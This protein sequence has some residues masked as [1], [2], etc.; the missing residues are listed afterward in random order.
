MQ[1]G[2]LPF[3]AATLE[4]EGFAHEFRV[5]L[6]MFGSGPD[7]FDRC[8]DLMHDARERNRQNPDRPLAVVDDRRNGASPRVSVIVSLYDA[9]TKLRTLLTGT[10]PAE[11][12]TA[13]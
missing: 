12:G 9:A 1:Y 6:A 7:A 3:V 13:R 8:L 2:D 10:E 11:C 4:R 5:A